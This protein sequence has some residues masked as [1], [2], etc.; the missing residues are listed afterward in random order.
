MTRR[1]PKRRRI[2]PRSAL[3]SAQGEIHEARTFLA[4]ATRVLDRIND[5]PAEP[6]LRAPISPADVALIM[7][8][9]LKQLDAAIHH[10]DEGLTFLKIGAGAAPT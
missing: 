1:K 5:S 4:I 8:L 10:L 3:A 9:G 6:T 7:G 2:D